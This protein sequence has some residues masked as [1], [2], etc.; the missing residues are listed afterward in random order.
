MTFNLISAHTML[1]AQSNDTDNN[2][3]VSAQSVEKAEMSLV[4]NQA[5]ARCEH[6][7]YTDACINPNP[8]ALLTPTTFE[9][10]STILDQLL[11]IETKRNL[12][13]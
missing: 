7:D 9:Q 1:C 8:P 13:G 5:Q 4:E 10:Q 6:A 11:P 3:Y 12:L 2:A